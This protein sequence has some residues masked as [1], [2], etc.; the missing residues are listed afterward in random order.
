MATIVGP[1]AKLDMGARVLAVLGRVESADGEIGDQVQAGIKHTVVVHSGCLR[2]YPRTFM[3]LLC[4]Q[5]RNDADA[6]PRHEMVQLRIIGWPTLGAWR[7][8][9]IVGA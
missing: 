2:A 5:R 3:F 9:G 7:H 1:A 4:E 8:G 6:G